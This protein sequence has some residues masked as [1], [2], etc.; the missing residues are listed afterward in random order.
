MVGAAGA[1]GADAAATEPTAVV[2][3]VVVALDTDGD[4]AATSDPDA[5]LTPPAPNVATAADASVKSEGGGN[6]D[7]AR[8]TVAV[9]LPA[10]V[11]AI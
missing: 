9:R 1:T 4:A 3:D 2:D 10:R 5:P 8:G 6:C 7:N 11:D